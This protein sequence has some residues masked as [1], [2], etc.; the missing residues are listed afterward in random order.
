[1]R[2]LVMAVTASLTFSVPAA[3]AQ[4]ASPSPSAALAGSNTGS[5]RSPGPAALVGTWT[6]EPFELALTSD[7]DKSV[8]G[9]NA[10]SVRTVTLQIGASGDATLTVTRKVVDGRKRTI[11]VSTSV[12]QAQIRI[13]QPRDAIDVRVEYDVTV[14]KA[15][16]RY[17]DEPDYRWTI[18]GLQVRVTG[19]DDRADILEVRFDPPDGKGSFWETVRRTSR[20]APKRTSG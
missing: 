7:F 1:M 5:G 10:T 4:T 13:G 20:T 12:E 2:T 15:E 16:R 11:P 6:S 3:L 17:P 18:D 14:L 19:F 9:A 8:W